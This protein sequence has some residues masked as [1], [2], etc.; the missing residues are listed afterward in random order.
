MDC[1]SN[2]FHKSKCAPELR[3]RE[4]SCELRTSS[5]EN[6]RPEARQ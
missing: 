1:A 6:L 4:N 5:G 3:P 2:A